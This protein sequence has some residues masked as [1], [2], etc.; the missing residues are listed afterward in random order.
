MKNKTY[1]GLILLVTSI[2]VSCTQITSNTSEKLQTYTYPD[3]I[4]ITPL[5]V[6]KTETEEILG[7]EK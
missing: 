2:L 1:L 4:K 7:I 6:K 3:G 5:K